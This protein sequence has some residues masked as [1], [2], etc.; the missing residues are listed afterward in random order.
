MVTFRSVYRV[1][2]VVVLVGLLGVL[3]GVVYLRTPRDLRV[4]RL[5]LPEG[6][7]VAVFAELEGARSMVLGDRG[8]LF[9]GTRGTGAVYAARDTDGDH[10]VDAV[11]T[12]ATGLHMPNGVAFRDGALYVAE[13]GRVLRYDLIEDRLDDPPEPR[14][15]IDGLP[16]ATWHGWRY[17]AFGPDG[18]L[19]IS[20]GV[21][22][23]VCL[24]RGE[25]RFGTVMR[26]DV[27]TGQGEIVAHGVRNSVGF[28]WH[29]ETGDLWFTDNGRDWLG[30]DAPPD[31]LNRLTSPGEH[32]G[33]PYC[34]GGV[35]RD[36]EFADRAC[37]EFTAPVQGLDAHVA[38]LGMHF[39]RGTMFPDAY[40]GRIFIAEHGS[41]NRVPPSGYRVT[42]VTLDGDAAVR[43]EPFAEGW[44]RG[45]RSSGTPA[46]VLELPDGSLLV[47]DDRGGVIYRIAY[48]AE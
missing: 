28:D 39:Y 41:W 15:V 45:G 48:G 19:Y 44:L 16:E 1:G 7:A 25:P 23:N 14:T 6:F 13:V 36:E 21:P 34:H 33:F 2:R 31:E 22:C 27:E 18:A 30:N 4:E 42:M 11:D 38:A 29:P 47:S 40:R 20:I 24:E 5:T 17:I 43:Y 46:D 26:F 37:D 12:I 35:V 3:G 10:R 9:V 8:T 32:F